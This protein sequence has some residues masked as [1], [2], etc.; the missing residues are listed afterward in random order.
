VNNSLDLTEYGK[1]INKVKQ[2]T[3]NKGTIGIFSQVVEKMVNIRDD[4]GKRIANK[5]YKSDS[6]FKLL[7]EEDFALKTLSNVFYGYL[8]FHNSRLFDV[9][10]ADSITKI[11]RE[12]LT[13]SKEKIDEINIELLPKYKTN[14]LKV[15]EFIYGDTDSSF[16]KVNVGSDRLEEVGGLILEKLNK[17]YFAFAKKY[18]IDSHKFKNKMERIY[19]TLL[20]NLKKVKGGLEVGTKKK[21]A[22]MLIWHK[23]KKLKELDIVGFETKRADSSLLAK[24]TQYKVLEMVLSRV[25]KEKI[26][27]YVKNIIRSIREGKQNLES[28]GI[29]ATITKPVEQYV[30][31]NNKPLNRPT[32]RALN[33]SN[34]HLGLGLRVGSRFKLIYVLNFPDTDVIAIDDSNIKFPLKINIKKH[35]DEV[36]KGKIG[37]IFIS[38]DWS[39]AE[40]SPQQSLVSY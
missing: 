26:V 13:Y 8:T 1:F 29:P 38:L 31:K 3:S 16:C 28:I 37:R 23:G 12:I 6:E 22:G 11:G 7:I 25:E 15:I 40:L 27:E 14:S 9:R 19:S 36:V 24:Q 30:D 32:L 10:I 20:F 33:W 34:K 35:I 18:N 5:Q 39:I 2:I 4:I 21:Y 17:S